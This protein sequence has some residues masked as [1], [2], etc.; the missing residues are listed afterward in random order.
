MRQITLPGLS[1]D[2]PAV[3]LQRVKKQQVLIT[4][5][6]VHCQ[7]YC[8]NWDSVI[9]IHE[10]IFELESKKMISKSSSP[11]SSPKWPVQK[12]SGEWRLTVDNRGLN[13]VTPS[14]SPAVPDMLEL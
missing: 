4:N 2:P 5:T 9:P 1:E 14:L 8:T 11:F 6:K 7:Q 10:M 3:R 13:E 12:S